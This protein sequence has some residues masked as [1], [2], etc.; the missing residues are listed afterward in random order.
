[1]ILMKDQHCEECFDYEQE[2]IPELNNSFTKAIKKSKKSLTR[3][4]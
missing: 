2:E 1:M 3:M 4:N